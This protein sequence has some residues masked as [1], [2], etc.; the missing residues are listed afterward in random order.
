M[1][2]YHC[3]ALRPSIVVAKR[4]QEVA[5]VVTKRLRKERNT[6]PD[7]EVGVLAVPARRTTALVLRDLHDALLASAAD[8]VHVARGLLHRNRGDDDRGD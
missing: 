7:V 5:T 1:S 3:H 2:T 4:Q 8:L 6:S